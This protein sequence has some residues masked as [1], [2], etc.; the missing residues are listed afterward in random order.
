PTLFFLAIIAPHVAIPAANPNPK[1]KTA[2]HIHLLAHF[3]SAFHFLSSLAT[4]RS[5]AAFSATGSPAIVNE[6][7]P[8]PGRR[9]R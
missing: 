4:S 1:N 8:P 3:I 2:A 5:A 6:S 9:S 7:N